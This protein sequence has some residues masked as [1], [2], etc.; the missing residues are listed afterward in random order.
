MIWCAEIGSMHKGDKSLAFELI[1]QAKQSGATIAKFQFGWTDDAQ[2]KYAG[3]INPIR[4]VDDWAEDLKRWCDYFDIELMASIWSIEGLETARRIGM[5]R[6][7]IAH[8]MRDERLIAEILSDGKE[9]FFS[10]DEE[11]DEPHI[12]HIFCSPH[13]PCYPEQVNIPDFYP[14]GWYY[15]YSDHTHGI[16]ACLLAVARGTQYIEKHFCLDK[17][18]LVVRDT[19]F[20]ATP[21]EFAEMVRIGNGI[22]RLLSVQEKL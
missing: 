11:N 1:R 22:S 6:Y 16:E 13:Y 4:Y 7:K 17:A 8:Q 10:N 18:D 3:N 9:T 12:K 14:R 19:P 21:Q 2:K 20:S 5:K 15:G